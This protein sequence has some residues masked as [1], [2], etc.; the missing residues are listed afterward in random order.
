MPSRAEWLDGGLA[1]L[2]ADG[3]P[4]LRIDGLARRLR[5]TK[6]SFYHHFVD[7]A[8]YR[9]AL[10]GHYEAICTRQQVVG[11]AALADL[12]ALVRLQR[13]ADTALERET[14]HSRLEFSVRAW[15]ALDDDVR[16]TVGRVDLQR[17]SYLEVLVTEAVG[18]AD[19]ARDRALILYYLLI[20]AQH[21]EPPGTAEELRRLWATL[22]DQVVVSAPSTATQP[23]SLEH[24][25]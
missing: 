19:R 24:P 21:A 23:A 5:V 3:L 1:V 9:R 7:L 14:V 4:G 22:I 17:L 2:A 6:G 16:Q 12:P 25:S 15:A 8:D 18:D 10:L 11:N 13:L 20:G